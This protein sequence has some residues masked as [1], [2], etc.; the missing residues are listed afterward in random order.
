MGILLTKLPIIYQ[1]YNTTATSYQ[2]AA[3]SASATGAAAS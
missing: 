2:T 1:N 3:V